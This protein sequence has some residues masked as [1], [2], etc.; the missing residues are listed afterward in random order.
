MKNIIYILLL[1]FSF[2]VFSQHRA[3]EIT[4]IESG[5]TKVYEENQRIKIRTLDG[6][7]HVGAVTFT[8]NETIV[9]DNQSIKIDSLQSIKSQPK[10]MGTV[11][12]IVLFTGLAVVATSLVVASGGGNAA[13]LLFTIG[14]G[15]TIGAGVL[16]ALNTNNSDRKWTFK[17]IEK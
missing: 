12:T 7:K 10:V 14:G 17:I 6:K 1:F 16:E 4:N 2:T 5:K 15:V 8:D 9:V 11:K 13:F 3:I